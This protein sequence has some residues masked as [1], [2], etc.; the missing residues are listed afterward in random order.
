[1]WEGFE[2]TRVLRGVTYHISVSR[3]GGGNAVSLV[4]DDQP[5]EGDVVPLSLVSE[6]RVEVQA[7]VG[8][9]NT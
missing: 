5:V 8:G 6:A 4:V 9:A 7:Y 3:V 1:M 2:A